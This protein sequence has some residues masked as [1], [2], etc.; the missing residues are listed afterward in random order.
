M[1]KCLHN[2]RLH[3]RL[4]VRVYARTC[5][6]KC[7]N[8][9]NKCQELPGQVSSN[10][11][12][13]VRIHFN[14]FQSK[15]NLRMLILRPGSQEVEYFFKHVLRLDSDMFMDTERRPRRSLPPP[16]L[17]VHGPRVSEANHFKK[18]VYLKVDLWI[19]IILYFA[20][21]CL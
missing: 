5:Q 11:R 13:H 17:R 10:V 18:V 16:C 1:S 3:V 20:Y 12:T 4:D 2:G 7:Q 6:D 15:I 21:R 8:P 9:H 19:K 14:I